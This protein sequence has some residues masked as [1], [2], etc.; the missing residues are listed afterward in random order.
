MYEECE[1]V[2]KGGHMIQHNK[3]FIAFKK[4]NCN[5]KFQFRDMASERKDFKICPDK[6]KN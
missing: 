4:N 1:R 6:K 2:I 5:C 3:K